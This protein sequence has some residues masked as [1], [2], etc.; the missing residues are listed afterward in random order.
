M[1]RVRTTKTASKNTA[2][3]IVRRG[4]HK[5]T[6]VKHIGTAKND[7]ELRELIEKANRY[8]IQTSKTTP[9]LPEVFKDSNSVNIDDLEF[10]NTYHTFA[11]EFL[12]Y[13]YDRCGFKKLNNELLRDLA[14][15]RVVEPCSKLQAVY[16]L[17]EY[18]GRNLGKTVMYEKLPLIRDLKKDIEESAVA[19]AKKYFTF[20]FSL[21]FYD[22]TT[23]YFES[24][25]ED[26][27]KKDDKGKVITGLRKP[28]FSKD[29]KSNQPQIVIGLIV[30]REGFPVSYDIFEGNTF[31]GKTFI[32]TI[33][34]FRDAYSV[35]KLIVVADAA[36]IS[37]DNVEKLKENTLSYIVGARVANLKQSQIEEVSKAI[38]G[39]DAKTIR[40]E[41]ERGLLICEF[42]IKRYDKDK[43]EMEKQI[44]RAE[45]LV[46]KN[47]EG[48]RAKF[49]KLKKERKKKEVLY[50]VN[51]TLAEKTKLLLGIKG[52][53]TNL[54]NEEDKTIIDHYHSLWHVEKAFRMAKSDLQ[55]R[56]IFHHKKESIEVHILIVFVSLCIAKAIELLTN[57]SI[58][59][60]KE[61]IWRILDIEF[62]D[63]FTKKEF[64]RRMVTRGSEMA[65]L[66]STLQNEN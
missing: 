1:Y 8:I 37:F 32:P 7:D 60:V 19:Y 39:T 4:D 10:T 25:K 29:N 16:L 50:E 47:A 49:L 17:R 46:E 26:E 54:T 13:F 48:K 23:L 6:V 59:K 43:R 9:L 63:T 41:T 31:E 35:K 61:M 51:A 62:I 57:L 5:I 20:D 30:T 2:V 27:D 64:R 42:S 11:Y 18:F 3:Q 36:M 66:L 34:K 56:P 22:V 44:A 15:I 28:G 45:K 58:K 38:S 65:K 55:A 14:I 24:F 40:I 12:S 52:Y 53:Y 21:V 33:T